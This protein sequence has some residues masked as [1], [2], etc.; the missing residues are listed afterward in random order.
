M[1][2]N[3]VKGYTAGILA[4]IFYGTNPLGTL[5]LYADGYTPS[6][7]LF[8]RYALAVAIFAVIMAVRGETFRIR[9]GHAI[10]MAFLGAFFALSSMTLYLSFKYMDA[11]VAS[12]ILFCYPIM[13]AVLMIAFFHERITW[14]TTLSIVLAVAGI[15][16]LYRGGGAGGTQLSTIGVALVMLSSLLYACYIIATGQVH[17]GF[18]PMRFTFWVLV[19]GGLSVVVWILVT[20]EHVALLHTPRQWACALQLALLPTVL[21]IFFINMAIDNIGPTPSAILGALE[22]VT[23]VFIGCVVYGENFSFRLAV[24]IVL[25]LSAVVLIITRKGRG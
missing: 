10:R 16:L 18:S 24:G 4:A 23:A 17:M 7:V 6:T 2:H 20:G 22:P 12:T 25:I 8:Y 9:P 11:G 3:L 19:F 13:T 14:T 15:G 1:N 5:A 21:S